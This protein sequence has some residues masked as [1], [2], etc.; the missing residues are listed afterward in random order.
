MISTKLLDLVTKTD[1][2]R[3]NSQFLNFFQAQ[4]LQSFFHHQ[5]HQKHLNLNL[6]DI[7]ELVLT[8]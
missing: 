1:A 3:S 2:P 4:I 7:V 6:H 8:P 5:N